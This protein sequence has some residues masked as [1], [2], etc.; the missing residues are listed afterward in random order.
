MQTLN[1][2]EVLI[3]KMNDLESRGMGCMGCSG[4]C[5]TYEANSMMVTP[6]EA[7]EL[8]VYLKENN[9][10][11]DELKTKF[12]ETVSK[13]RLEHPPIRGRRSYLRKTYT[14][15]FF[16]HQEL[17]C[18]LPRE[19][20]PYGCLAFDSHHAE[21]KASEHCYSEK[22]LLEQRELLHPEEKELNE[23]LKEKHELYW[24][25]TP[26][27]NALLDLWDYFKLPK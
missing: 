2:R 7:V 16:N 8:M 11:S 21:I 4:N 26:M 25:K 12:T 24:D 6:L 3:E 23:K 14:C 18:P 15:P 10:L 5:C 9:L 13:Y 27:P 22:D 19:I 1:R 17:G 20:K